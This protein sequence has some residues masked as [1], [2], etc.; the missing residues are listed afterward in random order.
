METYR[1]N[2]NTH[3]AVGFFNLKKKNEKRKEVLQI[4][5]NKSKRF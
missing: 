3:I 2:Q 1:D 4:I 5:N